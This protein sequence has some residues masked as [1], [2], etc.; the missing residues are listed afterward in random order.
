MQTTQ[1]LLD[2]Y[3]KGLAARSG[4]DEVIADDFTFTG[5]SPNTGTV[6]K[7]AYIEALRRFGRV[8]EKVTIGRR[9]VE[10]DAAAVVVTYDLVSPSGRKTTMDI[11]ELWTARANRLASLT[12]FYDTATWQ[13]FMAS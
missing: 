7:A 12:V 3:Y 2:V 8:F 13:S 6:G 1:T 11:V 10:G 9:I 4:W 5:A